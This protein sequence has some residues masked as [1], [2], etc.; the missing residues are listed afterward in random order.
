MKNTLI[1]FLIS[2]LSFSQKKE[3]KNDSLYFYFDHNNDNLEFNPE[4]FKGEVILNKYKLKLNNINYA[5]IYFL[6]NVSSDKKPFK[7][8]KSDFLKKNK[9]KIKYTK[10]YVDKTFSRVVTQ[11]SKYQSMFII[12]TKKSTEDS[13]YIVKIR[14]VTYLPMKM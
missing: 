6:D 14:M 13:L 2:F 11:I 5:P 12:D 8:L 1:I 4:Y 7:V 10:D 9:K 3:N